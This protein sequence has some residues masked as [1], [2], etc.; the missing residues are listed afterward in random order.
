MFKFILALLAILVTIYLDFVV[1]LIK[2]APFSSV[3]GIATI[4]DRILFI[5]FIALIWYAWE[6]KR[7][8]EISQEPILLLY[9]RNIKDYKEEKQKQ[10]EEYIIGSGRGDMQKAMFLHTSDNY[11]LRMRNVGSG[12]AFNVKVGNKNYEVEKYQAQFFAPHSDEQ[13]IKLI[14]KNNKPWGAEV[15]N[16]EILEITC[17][18]IN[19]K[20]YKFKYKIVDLEK[21]QIEFIK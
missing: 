19:K 3:R 16:E 4:G 5:T 21:Q 18:S 10:Q 7:I 6:T 11:L 9:I 1:S 20:K 12:A 17:E 13:S 14:S 15:L 8:R 2:M